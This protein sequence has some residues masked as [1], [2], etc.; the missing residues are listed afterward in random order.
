M[1][2]TDLKSHCPINF[3]LEV[4]GDSWSLLIIRD[5]I[6]FGKRT[7]GQF[8]TSDEGISSNILA[9]R[10]LTLEKKGII[11]KK[12]HETDKRK[13]LYFLTEKGL[14]LLPILL[15]MADWGAKHDPETN[16]P[17]DWI[18]LVRAD[19]ERMIGLIRETIKSRG[20]IFEG[21]DSVIDKL[22]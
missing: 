22:T 5:I 1:K 2:R 16:A 17:Q 3:S 21:P 18:E 6:Y 12:H 19:R 4:I 20:S 14:D 8:L 9:T 15:E 11:A 13:E 7:F 10:L